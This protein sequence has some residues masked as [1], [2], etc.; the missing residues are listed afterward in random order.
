MLSGFLIAFYTTGIIYTN[1]NSIFTKKCPNH[2]NPYQLFGTWTS[3]FTIEN[4]ETIPIEIEN[5]K[6]KSFWLFARHG[7]RNPGDKDLSLMKERVPLLQV[8][9]LNNH[10]N[11]NGQ[12]CQNDLATLAQWIF[13]LTIDDA[14]LLVESGKKE[15]REMGQRF[16]IRFP[17]LFEDFNEKEVIFR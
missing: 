17:T 7:S 15:M 13:D 14:Y 16:K 9:I 5:C 6:P 3:Y 10:L 2:Q 8:A 11:G 1:A 4:N 12:L